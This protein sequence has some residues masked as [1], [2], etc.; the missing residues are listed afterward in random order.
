MNPSARSIDNLQYQCDTSRFKLLW[1]PP[2]LPRFLVVLHFAPLIFNRNCCFSRI[3]HVPNWQLQSFWFATSIWP[4][5]RPMIFCSLHLGSCGGFSYGKSFGV[6]F[7]CSFGFNRFVS[8][9]LALWFQ[10]PSAPEFFRK[11]HHFLTSS[12]RIPHMK[13]AH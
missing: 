7:L 13:P 4:G 2:S 8:G 9:A 1:L 3:F 6:I 5:F 11:L 12:F 10:W